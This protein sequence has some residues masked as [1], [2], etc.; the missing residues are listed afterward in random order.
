MSR[1][2][3]ESETAR[4]EAWREQALK[5]CARHDTLLEKYHALKVSGAAPA[6]PHPTL[7][8]PEF[9]PV[10]AAITA[11]AGP[12]RKLR[13]MMSREAMEARRLGMPDH[14]IVAQIERGVELDMEEGIPA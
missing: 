11:K 5:D 8:R 1:A 6:E 4:A 9:D 2:A 13:A 10:L 14:E 3:L 7:T 12:D